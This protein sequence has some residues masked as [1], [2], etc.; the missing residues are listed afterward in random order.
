MDETNVQLTVQ[1]CGRGQLE[2]N[3][4]FNE[5]QV[6]LYSMNELLPVRLP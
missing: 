3:V 2:S 5:W 1:V 4:R 6:D